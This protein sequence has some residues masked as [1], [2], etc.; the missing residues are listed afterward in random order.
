[1]CAS[2][3]PPALARR[4]F[5]GAS[6]LGARL[7]LD[8]EH[9][10]RVVGVVG[11]VRASQLG[12]PAYPQIYLPLAQAP[13][14]RVLLAVRAQDAAAPGL[15]A[16]LRRE[17]AALDPQLPLAEVQPLE[18]YLE[19]AVQAPR[20]NVLVLGLFA[21]VAL[22]LAALGIYGMMASAVAQRTREIGIRMALGAEAQHVVR[23]V[24]G[25]GMLPALAG[26]ALGL[27]GALA[28]SRLLAGLLYGVGAT[29]LLTFALVSLGLMGVAL[30]ATWLP[31]RRATRVQPTEALRA[32]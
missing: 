16:G 18:T 27:L 6:P 19:R 2:C 23:L 3:T 11:D 25:Q 9:Y 20:V 7:T 1:M 24:V 13:S 30:L 28:A 12:E 32:E 10:F 14:A 15:T 22:V 31:A 5:P 4:Y 29:D 17:V 26:V 21:A 8:G